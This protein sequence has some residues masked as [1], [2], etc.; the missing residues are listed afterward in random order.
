MID[1]ER[2]DDST[3]KGDFSKMYHHQVA[4]LNNPDQNIEFVFGESNNYHQ[5]GNA[6]LQR[7]KTRRKVDNTTSNDEAIELINNAFPYTFKEGR[8]ATPGGSDL[9]HEK[10]VGQI[11]S[12]LRLLTNKDGGLKHFLMKF[13]KT[14][15]IIHLWKKFSITIAIKMIK[16]QNI[17][18][19]YNFNIYLDCA[20]HLKKL[21]RA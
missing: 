21:P 8:R 4:N 15:M 17:K 3:V 20:E 5:I 16:E 19:F 12:I 2:I 9:E 10:Y 11:S 6:Y 7:D 18:N 1:E 13:L 14:K